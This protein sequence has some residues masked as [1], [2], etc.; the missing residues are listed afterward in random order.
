MEPFIIVNGGYG[1]GPY[2]RATEIA[3][4][5]I[6]LLPEK[7]S[8]LVPHLYGSIQGRIMLEEF[9]DREDIVLDATYGSLLRELFFEGDSYAEFLHHFLKKRKEVEENVKA[10]LKKQYG[11]AITMEV[12]RAPLIHTGTTPS[13]FNSFARTS[14]IL[15][16]SIDQEEIAIENDLLID[17]ADAM[18]DLESRY[19]LMM[20]SEPGTFEDTGNAETIPP[21]VTMKDYSG[22]EPE[23]GIYVTVSGIPNVA[24]L[25]SITSRFNCTIYSNA[26]DKVPGSI[27][28]PP[29]ILAHK[30]IFLHV[31]RSGWGAVWSSLLTETPL[32]T[33]PYTSTD[34]PEIFFNNNRIEDLGIGMVDRGLSS[35]DLAKSAEILAP[36]IA[37]YKKTLKEKYGTLDGA[38]VAATLIVDHCP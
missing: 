14:D 5:V 31:A 18:Q 36:K 19:S 22:E 21:S 33:P 25:H 16:K 20:L 2:L 10:H 8:I 28:A 26:P 15:R 4:K 24:H 34:D 12:S 38:S 3:L 9:G 30:N 37:T 23:F 27:G 7:H 17:A 13:F 11:D 1:N 35:D 29:S 6:D 32:L